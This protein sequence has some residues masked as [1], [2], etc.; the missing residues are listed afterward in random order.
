MGGD[1]GVPDTPVALEHSGAQVTI[2]LA[3]LVANWQDLQSRFSG[4]TCGATIKANAYGL[5][6][7]PIVKALGAAGCRTFFVAL[8]QEGL[9]AR[10]AAPEAD[11]YVLNG[12]F[13]DQAEFY[14]TNR[15]TP[16]LATQDEFE[17][18]AQYAER[19]NQRLPAAIHV[20]TGMNRLGLKSDVFHRLIENQGLM[21]QI[22]PSLVMSHLACADTPDHAMNREQ[23]ARFKAV[24]SALPGIPASL[25]NSAGI[26]LGSDFHF[27]IARPGIALYGG[28]AV[29]GIAN[30]MKPVVSVKARVLQTRIVRSG[31]SVGYGAAQTADRDMKVA[32]LSCGYADGYTRLAGS[33]DQR[34]GAKAFVAGKAVPLIGR[35]SMDMIAVDVTDIP[36]NLCQRGSMV[37][38]FGEN[39]AVDDVARACDT[40]GY[41][42]LTGIGARAHRH[43]KPYIAEKVV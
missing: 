3:A 4:G 28:E 33:S 19:T 6:L 39:I 10:T 22:E 32:T 17:E 1:L 12:L 25:C 30:P 40:I 16:V 34:R 37:E 26:F 35:V 42:L 21:T 29:A 18:W 23:L 36:D 38:L 11:I 41:E 8:P 24:C 27:D 7:A 5:G 43:Y 20:D 14:A 13:M 9:L 31:E 15:L 2:D